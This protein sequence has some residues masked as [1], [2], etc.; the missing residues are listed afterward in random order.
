[1]SANIIVPRRL[2]EFLRSLTW[3][4]KN[5]DTNIDS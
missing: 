2:E 3:K 5:R 1:M 4:R